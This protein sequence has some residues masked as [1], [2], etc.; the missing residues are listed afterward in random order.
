MIVKPGRSVK[1]K[2]CSVAVLEEKDYQLLHSSKFS[3]VTVTINK[4]KFVSTRAL[5]QY[6]VRSTRPDICASVQLLA[7]NS[8]DPSK[9]D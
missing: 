4:E 5:L 9:D 7:R 2:S 1:F 3:N 6:I 8:D